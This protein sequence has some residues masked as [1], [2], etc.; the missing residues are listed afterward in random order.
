[1]TP[2]SGFDKVRTLKSISYLTGFQG[3][4]LLL[5]RHSHRVSAA[6]VDEDFKGA[7][8]SNTLVK[9]LFT[10]TEDGCQSVIRVSSHPGKCHSYQVIYFDD[11]ESILNVAFAGRAIRIL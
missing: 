5:D 11:P 8:V 2:R 3:L 1:M 9:F 7:K 4:T 10:R 6:T